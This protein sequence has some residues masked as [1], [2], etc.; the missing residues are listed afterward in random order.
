M[1]TTSLLVFSQEEAQTLRDVIASPLLTQEPEYLRVLTHFV[2][3]TDGLVV[4]EIKVFTTREI[5]ND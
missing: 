3:A 5:A 2:K 4:D 1:R